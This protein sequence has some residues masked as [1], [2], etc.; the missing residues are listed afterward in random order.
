MKKKHLTFIVIISFGVLLHAQRKFTLL[1]YHRISSGTIY[2]EN[3]EIKGSVYLFDKWNNKNTV[4]L[5]NGKTTKA[6]SINI[7]VDTNKLVIKQDGLIY[8]IE[9]EY[10]KHIIIDNKMYKVFSFNKENKIY[11]VVEKAKNNTL[12]RGYKVTYV[13]AKVKPYQMDNNKSDEY[14]K[15]SSYYIK[16]E[17]SIKRIKLKKKSILKLFEDKKDAIVQYVKQN[18]LSYKKEKDVKKIFK[19]YHNL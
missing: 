18:R 7:N 11:E 6:D 3:R 4:Y 1:G 19:Y 5:N 9:K 13:V 16:K 2:I 12:L 10:Y 14:K 17:N 8:N 15:Q